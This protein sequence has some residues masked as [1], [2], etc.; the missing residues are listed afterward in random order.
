M[1]LSKRIGRSRVALL[2]MSRVLAWYICVVYLTTRWRVE[3]RE[4]A[5]TLIQAGEPFIAGFWHGRLMLAPHGWRE[6]K[7][8]HVMISLHR[9]GEWITRTVQHLGVEAIRGSASKGGSTAVRAAI[10]VLGQ[11]GYVGITPD[12]PRGPRMRVQPG[13]ILLAK[14]TQVPILPATYA[15]SRRK[16]AGS[17][18]R[19]LFALPFSRGIY[20]WGSPI[21]VRKDADDKAIEEARLQLECQL[22]RLTARADQAVGVLPIEPDQVECHDPEESLPVDKGVY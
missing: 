2:L 3:G 1:R 20:V 14:I 5:E 13:V 8:I 10:R 11:G 9:D 18:D 16:I 19:F 15:V 22:N 7:P 6:A 17:W 12:G 21:R 4:E